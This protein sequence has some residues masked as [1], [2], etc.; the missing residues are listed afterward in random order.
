MGHFHYVKIPE[1][2]GSQGSMA[3]TRATGATFQFFGTGLIMCL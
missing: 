1:A 2:I 3:A